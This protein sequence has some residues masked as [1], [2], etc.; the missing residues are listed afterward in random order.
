[1]RQQFH[2]DSLVVLE[3]QRAPALISERPSRANLGVN[4]GQ[5]F[6]VMKAVDD[7]GSGELRG[8]DAADAEAI[9]AQGV[10]MAAVVQRSPPDRARSD[11][12][13]LKLVD[14]DGRRG[15]AVRPLLSQSR[16]G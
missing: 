7:A 16:R 2:C 1:M 11:E 8:P 14:G 13:D 3:P 5:L 4:A 9:D 15:L 12:C 10:R 6:S